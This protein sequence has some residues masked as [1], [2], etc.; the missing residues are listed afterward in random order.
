MPQG[1]LEPASPAPLLFYFAQSCL[2]QL[3]F[4]LSCSE[5]E[6][7]GKINSCRL[8]PMQFLICSPSAILLELIFRKIVK[9][10][11]RLYTPYFPK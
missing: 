11:L 9:D 4:L 10:K 1:R 7:F 8:N 2:K 6:F 5:L 3:N